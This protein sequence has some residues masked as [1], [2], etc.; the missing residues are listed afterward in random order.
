MGVR[1]WL[2]QSRL[3]P[4]GAHP[5]CNTQGARA[6]ERDAVSSPGMRDAVP[7]AAIAGPTAPWTLWQQL[8]VAD[9]FTCRAGNSP[10]CDSALHGG[11][12]RRAAEFVE[13]GHDGR[14]QGL[15]KLV[16]RPA[17]RRF[18]TRQT[19]HSWPQRRRCAELSS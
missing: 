11:G 7:A 4:S 18:G 13:V 3:H 16:N 6:R 9:M 15:G 12:Q 19:P 8:R 10:R 5:A 2:S 1:Q 17:E 14:R